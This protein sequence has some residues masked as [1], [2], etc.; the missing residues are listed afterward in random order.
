M[1]IPGDLIRDKRK[2]KG[3]SQTVLGDFVGMSAATVHRIEHGQR[4]PT[5]QEASMIAGMLNL[6]AAELIELFNQVRNQPPSKGSVV[7]ETS[8]RIAWEY[9]HPANYAGRVWIEVYPQPQTRHLPHEL[10]LR[11]GPYEY[12]MTLQ[13]AD[14]QEFISLLHFKSNDNEGLPI[15]AQ[16]SHPSYLVFGKEAPPVTPNFTLYTGWRRV[17]PYDA[18]QVLRFAGHFLRSLPGMLWAQLRQ[19][20]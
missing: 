15:L 7:P 12:R 10:T 9:A 18:R 20:S 2:R 6:D 11:W 16:V 1:K 13:F 3:W 8:F 14:Q 5:D 4:I 17:E 19:R